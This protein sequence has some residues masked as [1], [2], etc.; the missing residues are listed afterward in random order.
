MPS[1][2]RTLPIVL[3]WLAAEATAD[4]GRQ[5]EELKALEAIDNMTDAELAPHVAEW[6][7]FISATEGEW[8]QVAEQHGIDIDHTL[9]WE[10]PRS[11]PSATKAKAARWLRNIGEDPTLTGIS[12]RAKLVIVELA[13]RLNIEGKQ[14]WDRIRNLELENQ[15]LEVEIEALEAKLDPEGEEIDESPVEFVDRTERAHFWTKCAPIGFYLNVNVDGDWMLRGY[16]GAAPRVVVDPP[17]ERTTVPGAMSKPENQALVDAVRASVESRLRGTRTFAPRWSNSVV[18]FFITI[19]LQDGLHRVNAGLR[20]PVL[21]LL[22]GERLEIDLAG[23]SFQGYN[24][25]RRDSEHFILSQLGRNLDEFLADY[26]RV[27]A[28]ACGAPEGVD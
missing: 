15:S 21:D 19:T 27:N 10:A 20:K 18:S 25:M 8:L 6:D 23:F 9:S 24:T 7:G 26:L 4:L 28:G 12:N 2:K 5:F 16:T 3:L 17:D 11:W 1:I 14:S 22:S 13:L